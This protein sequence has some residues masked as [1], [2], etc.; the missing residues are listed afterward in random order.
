MRRLAHG[1]AGR[2]VFPAPALWK[3]AC[4]YGPHVRTT[5]FLAGTLW[6]C[7]AALRAGDAGPF[8]S[9]DVAIADRLAG[10]LTASEA[11]GP[12]AHIPPPAGM[13]ALA[14][15]VAAPAGTPRVNRYGTGYPGRAAAAMDPALAR[16]ERLRPL[17]EPILR[18]EGLPVELLAVV[19]VES[20]GNSQALSPRS[21]RGLWQLI[22]A[23]AERY[24]LTVGAAR[25]ERLHIERSTW[26]AAR[27][28]RDLYRQFGNWELA[29]AA[30]NAGEDAVNRAIR[31]AGAAGFQAVRPLLPAETRRYV[32]AVLAAMELVGGAPAPPPRRSVVYA[33]T[34]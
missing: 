6:A 17:M 30:Y 27:Y 11:P 24:G 32:P 9:Y 19:L 1:R 23:T 7:S 15:E 21:A 10:M 28:L 34:G 16:L 14:P 31:K 5:I 25:D 12:P 3:H 26:A 2:L 22:P 20:G 8:A 29:L 4:S 13:P 18:A 33:T